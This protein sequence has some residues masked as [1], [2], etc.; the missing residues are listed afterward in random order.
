MKNQKG[1]IQIPLVI[2]IIA[3]ILVLSG[4][5]YFGVKQYQSYQAQQVKKEKIAQEAQ[6]QKDL[7]VEKLRQEMEALKN[8]KPEIIQQTIV[9][10]APT[11]TTNNDEIVTGDIQRYIPFI[12]NINCY[13]NFG[14]GIVSGSGFILNIAGI[15]KVITN[16]HVINGYGPNCQ[17]L[18][19]TYNEDNPAGLR[20][21]QLDVQNAKAWN[22]LADEAVLDI[23]TIM[24]IPYSNTTYDFNEKAELE[25]SV[26]KISSTVSNLSNCPV[27]MPLGTKVA[28]IGYPVTTQH[29][30][31]LQG[32][33][34]QK[35]KLTVN[36]R[37]IT[38]GTISAYDDSQSSFLPYSNYF[39]TA[40]IDSGNSGGLALSKTN[41][42]VCLLGMP[43]WV[44]AGNFQNQ[45]IIQN[46]NNVMYK[47]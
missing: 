41:G 22:S 42:A 9:K 23:S 7:E 21:Y 6:Q 3:G 33:D 39:T 34:P 44:S 43:T 24:M 30:E 18:F 40:A 47:L 19:R 46:M 14:S 31:Q 15:P 25:P 2:A 17:I 1:F 36:P 45:G 38:F 32:I 37:T 5:G 29:S 20:V 12:G 10:E 11:P 16:N 35:F 13:V 4:A 28:V 8:K 27:K 26:S